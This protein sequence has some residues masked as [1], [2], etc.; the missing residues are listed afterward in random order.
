MDVATSSSISEERAATPVD[1]S[2]G[3]EPALGSRPRWQ[4]WLAAYHES[5]WAPAALKAAGS[6][7]LIAALAVIGTVHVARDARGFVVSALASA[8]DAP[9]AHDLGAAWLARSHEESHERVAAPAESAA[10]APSGAPAPPPGGDAMTSDGKVI[11]NRAGVAELRRLPGIGKKR[12][13]AILALRE[14]LGRF[15][16]VTDLLRVRGIGPRAVK[17]IAPHAVVDPP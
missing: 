2:E 7:A 11:L 14:R 4:R 5:V 3:G 17:K 10:P 6:L 16:R 13:E 12:A 15:R 1:G 9:L 8:S